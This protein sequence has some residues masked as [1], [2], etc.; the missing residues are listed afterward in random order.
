MS[1]SPRP[2]SSS[3]SALPGAYATFSG[4]WTRDHLSRA[5]ARLAEEEDEIVQELPIIL[6]QEMSHQSYVMQQPL[7]PA[8]RPYESE[9][10][11]RVSMR[12][13]PIQKKVEMEFT[14]EDAGVRYQNGVAVPNISAGGGREERGRNYNADHK[15]PVRKVTLLA[16]PVPPKTNYAVGVLTNGVLHLTPV[17]AV[18]RFKPSLSYIDAAAEAA[19]AEAEAKKIAHRYDRMREGLMTEEEEMAMEEEAYAKIKEEESK[20]ELSAVIMKVKKSSAAASGAAAGLGPGVMRKQTY[21]F[22]K[23]LEEKEDWIPLK[24]NEQDTPTA[25]EDFTRLLH[26][27]PSTAPP[28]PFNVPPASYLSYVN[29]PDLSESQSGGQSLIA[30][31]DPLYLTFDERILYF[32]RNCRLVHC[33]DLCIKMNIHTEDKLEAA[34]RELSNICWIVQGCWVLK[35]GIVFDRSWRPGLPVPSPTLSVTTSVSGATAGMRFRRVAPR[36]QLSR[37]YL[38]TQFAKNRVV[39]R[40]ELQKIMQIEVEHMDE[41]LNELA[42]KKDVSEEQMEKGGIARGAM[43]E[44]KLDTDQM[45]MRTFPKLVAQSEQQLPHLENE[46]R[47]LLLSTAPLS[48]LIEAS[49]GLT[50]SN[51]PEIVHGLAPAGIAGTRHTPGQPTPKREEASDTVKDEPLTM[52]DDDAAAASC[53]MPPPAGSSI[54]DWRSHLHTLFHSHGILAKSFVESELAART[55][56]GSEQLASHLRSVVEHE[57]R[58]FGPGQSRLML[59]SRGTMLDARTAVAGLFTETTS[60]TTAQIRSVLPRGINDERRRE[61]MKEFATFQPSTQSWILKAGQP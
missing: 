26:P 44:W 50:L 43:W 59:I 27:D 30:T 14:L 4:M 35:S 56:S 11:E 28:I 24:V 8:H 21:A 39:Y 37:E 38:L 34:I 33:S 57:T 10:G 36:Q 46:L 19:L 47:T 42:V 16:K 2:P 29:P 51:T 22:L 55:A 25:Q 53:V 1:A 18:C 54:D 49:R 32:M 6:S 48:P 52:A 23:Q 5:E 3:A 31:G 40:D 45:F 41:L 12:V 9:L 58:A 15:Y 20:K 17:H 13:K 7:R 61:I 60:V